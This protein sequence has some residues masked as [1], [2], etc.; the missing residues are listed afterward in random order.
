MAFHPQI[1]QQASFDLHCKIGLQRTA[2][3]AVA[4]DVD[5]ILSRSIENDKML[6]RQH[7]SDRIIAFK[8]L[9]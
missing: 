7:G 1:L 3:F 2:A 8:R 4:K 9:P 5:L 6:T